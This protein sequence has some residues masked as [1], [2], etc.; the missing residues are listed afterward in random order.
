MLNGGLVTRRRRDR[1]YISRD[2]YPPD[3]LLGSR[4]TPS[5]APADPV[6]SAAPVETNTAHLIWGV[7]GIAVALIAI[8]ALLALVVLSP[9]GWRWGVILAFAAVTAWLWGKGPK[10]QPGFVATWFF[11]LFLVALGILGLDVLPQ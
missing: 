7:A 10:E 4:P 9:E 2:D 8:A 1:D 3:S 5:P 6:P 11:V